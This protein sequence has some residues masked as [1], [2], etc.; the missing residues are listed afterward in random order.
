MPCYPAL[1]LLIGSAMATESSW[2]TR[3]TRILGVIAAVAAVACF[4]IAFEVRNL[5]TPGDISKA[6]SSHPSAYTLSLGHM[7][8]L[9]FDSFAY[10]RLPLVLAGIA[11][12]VGAFGNLLNKEVRAAVLT[13]VMMIVFF[14][15]ARFA[16]VVFDP[17]LSSRP[18]AHA[19]VK[20]APGKL[21]LDHHYYTF[22]SVVFYTGTD[23]LLLNGKFNNLEYGGAAPDCPQVFL[24]D[25]QF[26]S[27]WRGG[28][29]YYLVGTNKAIT[30][31]ESLVGSE[32]VRTVAESGGKKLVTNQ[33]L[34]D[35]LPAIH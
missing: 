24:N 1:A 8:D 18:L 25:A 31:I 16:L 7:L 15:A 9:T 10:L 17:F 21:I 22:S 12:S 34:A 28:D 14:H 23:P 26:A 27:L 4:V 2:I 30:R 11:F 33:E 19:Y 32:A 35:G 6:L 13:A 5:P 29:R 3:G 20:S